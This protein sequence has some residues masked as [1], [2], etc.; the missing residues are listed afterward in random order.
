MVVPIEKRLRGPIHHWGCGENHVLKYCPYKIGNHRGIHN[1]EEATIVEY[2]EKETPK[3]YGALD[4]NQANHQA[5]V[6]E[7]EGKIA[8]KTLSIFF[9]TGSP[10]SYVTSKV[11][12][13]YSPKKKK[14][15]KSCLFQLAT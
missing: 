13:I 3:I 6:V 5:I 10:H 2:M 15:T 1:I 11:G 12:E 8:K 14:H 4:G 9:D 7:V